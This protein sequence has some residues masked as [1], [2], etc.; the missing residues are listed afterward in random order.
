MATKSKSMSNCFRP[1]VEVLE[2][3][4][5]PST[6]YLAPTGSDANAGEDR[7]SA[8]GG[9][10]ALTLAQWRSQTGRDYLENRAVY[11]SACSVKQPL[12][13]DEGD[14]LRQEAFPCG[15]RPRPPNTP[16]GGLGQGGCTQDAN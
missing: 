2:T 14:A 3:R 5:V 7:Y 9:N 15:K 6:F 10:T 16:F 1:Q 8:D 12:F 11:L 13:M 4:E